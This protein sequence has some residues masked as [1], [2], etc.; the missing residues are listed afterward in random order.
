MCQSGGEHPRRRLSV[1]SQRQ[2]IGQRHRNLQDQTWYNLLD[3]DRLPPSLLNPDSIKVR[4]QIGELRIARSAY[5]LY[6]LSLPS[7]ERSRLFPLPRKQQRNIPRRIHPAV[8]CEQVG[9]LS[10]RLKQLSLEFKPQFP[11]CERH[12]STCPR[13]PPTRDRWSEDKSANV[14]PIH[15][16]IIPEMSG[17]WHRACR[18]PEKV[19]EPV[20][21]SSNC[22]LSNPSVA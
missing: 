18:H 10:A 13:H 21:A 22:A 2:M 20:L 6:S 16:C 9:S 12:W 5:V 7:L 1:P 11:S 15:T 3:K 8:V 19:R 17:R 14:L 4:P